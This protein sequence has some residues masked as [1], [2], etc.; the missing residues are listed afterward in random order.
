MKKI[1]APVPN[2]ALGDNVNSAQMPT[3]SDNAT[4]EQ[5]GDQA[6]S[7]SNTRPNTPVLGPALKLGAG[8]GVLSPTLLNHFL[9]PMN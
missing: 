9:Q 7:F 2:Q 5:T 1:V 6:P 4:K 3:I 8:V